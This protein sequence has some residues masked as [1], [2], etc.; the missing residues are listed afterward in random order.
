[1]IDEGGQRLVPQGAASRARR[2]AG[3]RAF[4]AGPSPGPGDGEDVV[5]PGEYLL[6]VGVVEVEGA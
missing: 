2:A 6:T 1:M 3:R 4:P 5:Q